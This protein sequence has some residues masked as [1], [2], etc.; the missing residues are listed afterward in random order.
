M[1]V[2]IVLGS[3]N[4]FIS[5]A[6]GAFGA[7]GLRYKVTSE[8]L[9]TWEKAVDYQMYHALALLIIALSIKLWPDVR[10]VRTAGFLFFVGIVLFSGSLYALVL[11]EIRMLGIITPIGGVA[12]LWGW[13]LFG[14]SARDFSDY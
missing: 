11:T 10:R 8:L 2:F 14:L 4:A 7:H 1:K 9:V 5:V 3:L 12:F 6:L 13:I